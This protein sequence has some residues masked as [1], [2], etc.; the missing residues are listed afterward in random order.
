[1]ALAVGWRR[2]IASSTV[3][4]V[5]ASRARTAMRACSQGERSARM[6]FSSTIAVR[7][8]ARSAGV[9]RKAGMAA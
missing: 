9:R 3:G 2:S 4:K 8:S 7:A 1:M 5:S 6:A